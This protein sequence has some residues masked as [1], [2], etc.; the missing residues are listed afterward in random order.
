MHSERLTIPILDCTV[1]YDVI[2]GGGESLLMPERRL[3]QS[4][5]YFTMRNPREP[6]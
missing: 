4:V 3:D 1:I 2:F 5:L 6:G